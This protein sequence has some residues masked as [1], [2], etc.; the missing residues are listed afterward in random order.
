VPYSG[1]SSVPSELHA[2]L[3]F[4]LIKFRVVC[5]CVCIMWRPGAYRSI[6]R[7]AP[8]VAYTKPH[9]TQN[10]INQ[11]PNWHVTQKVQTSSLRTQLPKHVGTAK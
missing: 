3:D 1:S 2:N 6:D 8:G 4:W 5:G 10:S 9:T 11:N 7:Y